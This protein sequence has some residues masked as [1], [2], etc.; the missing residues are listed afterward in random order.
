MAIRLPKTTVLDVTQ[1]DVSGS[2]AGGWAY[3]FNLPQDT[4]NVIVKFTPSVTAGGASV[5]FQTTDDGGST[6]YDV[7]RSSIASNNLLGPFWMTV[8]TTAGLTTRASVVCT[9]SVVAVNTGG[10]AGA[11]TLVANFGPTYSGLPIMGIQNRVFVITA[12]NATAVS[13]RVVVFANQQSATA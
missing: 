8:P 1:T 11:S 12:G 3:P 7:A 9:G 4:D 10:Q 5:T 13:A 6:W 2:V